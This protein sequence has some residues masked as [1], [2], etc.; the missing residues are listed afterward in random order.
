MGRGNVIR[1]WGL[2]QECCVFRVYGLRSLGHRV[3][4]PTWLK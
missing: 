4:G 3:S 2:Q 1:H